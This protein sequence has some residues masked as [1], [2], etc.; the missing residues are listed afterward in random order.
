M[1]FDNLLVTDVR[2][3]LPGKVVARTLLA[4]GNN[5]ASN[6]R[7]RYTVIRLRFSV[8]VTRNNERFIVRVH[9]Q[10]HAPCN[11]QHL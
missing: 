2:V 5:E 9:G 6:M 4:A 7:G 10:H 1:Y 3:S 8:P 11:T